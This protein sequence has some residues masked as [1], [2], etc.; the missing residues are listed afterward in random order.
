M[1]CCL[2]SNF[3][4]SY[5]VTKYSKTNR[6][7]TYRALVF[8]NI[9]R[10]IGEVWSIKIIDKKNDDCIVYERYLSKQPSYFN[11]FYRYRKT[12]W[13]GNTFILMDKSGI[14]WNRINV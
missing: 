5:E 4:L 2:K 1:R 3:S 7:R 10:V 8:R 11:G 12:F 6:S 9:N 13:D 14:V